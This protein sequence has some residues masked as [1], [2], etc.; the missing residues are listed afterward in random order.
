MYKIPIHK[1]KPNMVVG[2]DIYNAAGS[3]LLRKGTKFT[4]QYL[5]HLKR[6]NIASVYIAPAD[7]KFTA[8]TV[9]DIIQE[10]TRVQAIKSVYTLFENY[11]LSKS[12][13]TQDLTANVK[14]ILQNL[15]SNR[16]NL[17]QVND[18]RLYD[19]YTFGHC[20]N[21]SV[22]ATMIGT[23]LHYS[24]EKLKELAL[25]ALLHDIGKVMLPLSILNKPTK[26]TSEEIE[27]IQTHPTYGYEILSKC[28]DLPACAKTIAHQHHEKFR[29]GGYPLGIAADQITPYARI[30]TIADVY[31]ALLADR[32]YKKAY[33]PSLAFKLMT[34][35]M[36]SFF[37]LSLLQL[38]FEHVAIYPVGS[39]LKLSNGYYGLVTKVEAGRT[40][41][42][43]LQLIADPQKHAIQQSIFLDTADR[44][45]GSIEYAL[46]EQESFH[47]LQTL[48]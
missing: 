21:V 15:V 31:D 11:H 46:D 20:V 16:S 28:D 23:L 6:L 26:L 9:D 18:I 33:T 7:F 32:P 2:R 1:L 14:D 30:V 5:A 8:P 45:N 40:Q 47:F 17:V 3:C 22:L 39:V 34:Q 37:D 4:E 12:L 19:D 27:I 29:G 13:N 38:F 25:G 36:R 48:H 44:E 24:T 41:T 35:S 42:P 43:E 10:K